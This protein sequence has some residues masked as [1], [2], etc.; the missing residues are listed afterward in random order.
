MRRTASREK[1]SQHVGT[2]YS[3]FQRAQPERS[4]IDPSMAFWTS[5][6]SV[7]LVRSLALDMDGVSL[8]QHFPQLMVKSVD[9]VECTQW[10]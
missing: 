10:S 7:Y 3:I 8:S 9:T 5:D 4:S 2:E 1:R 6:V